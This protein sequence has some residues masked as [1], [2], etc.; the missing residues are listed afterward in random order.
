M[1][2]RTHLIEVN[3]K[4]IIHSAPIFTLAEFVTSKTK[5]DRGLFLTMRRLNGPMVHIIW[6]KW[7][8]RKMSPC[9]SNKVEPNEG[10]FASGEEPF[11]K[12]I[13]EYLC[14]KSLMI[15]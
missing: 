7:A 6:D 12:S 9:V 8:T 13:T 14:A 15:C 4:P 10:T 1:N 11:D 2:H 5:E 3:L